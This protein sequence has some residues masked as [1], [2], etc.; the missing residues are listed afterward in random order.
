MIYLDKYIVESF[1]TTTKHSYYILLSD[2]QIRQN[3]A[4]LSRINNTL[5]LY[6]R[7]QEVVEFNIVNFQS[8]SLS[9]HVS[10]S[11][12]LK[13]LSKCFHFNLRNEEESVHPFSLRNNKTPLDFWEKNP[14]NIEPRD[15]QSWVIGW[16]VAKSF[17]CKTKNLL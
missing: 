13:A 14:F 11:V 15:G 1:S 6:L 16:P 17:E 3:E 9:Q 7:N 12:N 2:F 10:P 8:S 4:W 5:R